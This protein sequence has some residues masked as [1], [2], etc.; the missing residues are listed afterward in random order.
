MQQ[1]LFD[2]INL[3]NKM[4]VII[5]SWSIS[6]NTMSCVSFQSLTVK[7]ATPTIQEAESVRPRSLSRASAC[8]SLTT[9]MIQELFENIHYFLNKIID[10]YKFIYFAIY[11]IYKCMHSN[12]NNNE[13][14]KNGHEKTNI[15]KQYFFI[16]ICIKLIKWQ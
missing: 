3:S 16:E 5:T 12:T 6:R 9:P 11:I 7:E 14:M 1:E 13:R 8:K 2:F 15:G 10:I 4:L